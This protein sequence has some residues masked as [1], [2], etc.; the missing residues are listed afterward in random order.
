[1]E[2][3]VKLFASDVFRSMKVCTP[4]P[5]RSLRITLHA[6]LHSQEYKADGQALGCKQHVSP[7]QAQNA[8]GRRYEVRGHARR[9]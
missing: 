5:K 7:E 6:C 4:R 1:M 3:Q 8:S 2:R 9:G